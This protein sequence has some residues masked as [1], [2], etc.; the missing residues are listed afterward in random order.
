[1]VITDEV[2]GL[3]WDMNL[4]VHVADIPDRD[5]VDKMRARYI[6]DVRADPQALQ[7]V[8]EDYAKRL[9]IALERAG[10][11]RCGGKEGLYVRLRRP[12]RAWK[13]GVSMLVPLDPSMEDFDDLLVAVHAELELISARG[14]LASQV[15]DEMEGKQR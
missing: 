2:I 5:A 1:M 8:A 14:R 12:P 13:G 9:V 3:Y 7:G 11:V 6:T 15:L 10:W 4:A